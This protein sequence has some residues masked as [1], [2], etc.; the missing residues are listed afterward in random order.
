MQH[1]KIRKY[2]KITRNQDRMMGEALL[3]T[4]TGKMVLQASHGQKG[5]LGKMSL[6]CDSVQQFVSC[7]SILKLLSKT[8]STS[9]LCIIPRSFVYKLKQC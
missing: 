6:W 3:C 7:S 1:C 8:Q 2:L 4:C 9:I 5:E